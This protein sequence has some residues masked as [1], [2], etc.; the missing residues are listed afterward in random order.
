MMLGMQSKKQEPRDTSHVHLNA[1]RCRLCSAILKLECF[2]ALHYFEVDT[3]GFPRRSLGFRILLGE[4]NA[5][6]NSTAAALSNRAMLPIATAASRRHKRLQSY[7][8][9]H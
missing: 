8:V 6:T 3:L 5:Q 9:M 7:L 4:A 1:F 2:L